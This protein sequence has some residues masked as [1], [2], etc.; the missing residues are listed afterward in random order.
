MCHC[1]RNV[2]LTCRVC[3]VNNNRLGANLDVD[4]CIKYLSLFMKDEE[5]FARI[6]EDY[7][8]GAMT[9]GEVKK[10]TVEVLM[11]IVNR[12]KAARAAITHEDVVQAMRVR[13]LFE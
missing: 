6:C 5:L 13:P 4:V 2:V 11:E 9:T 3:P 8:S 10:H 7:A 12:H 1:T